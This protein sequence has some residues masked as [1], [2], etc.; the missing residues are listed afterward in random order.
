M[1][2]VSPHS[3]DAGFPLVEDQADMG[4]RRAKFTRGMHL[5]AIALTCGRIILSDQANGLVWTTTV[6]EGRDENTIIIFNP[7]TIIRIVQI[8]STL[9]HYDDGDE[10]NHHYSRH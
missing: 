10:E 7:L 3:F 1:T 5:S 8:D 2:G 4:V 6:E 9:H